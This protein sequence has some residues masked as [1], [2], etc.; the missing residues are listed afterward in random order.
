MFQPL[1]SLYTDAGAPPFASD[2]VEVYG[3]RFLT[4]ILI[5]GIALLLFSLLRYR[6]RTPSLAAW[7]LLFLGVVILPFVSTMFGTLLVFARGETVE[8]CGSCHG[9]MQPY[10][11]DMRDPNSQS[12]AALHFKNGYIPRSQCY[13]CHTSFGMFGTLEA[14]IGGIVQ[15]HRY[16]TGTFRRP[17]RMREPYRNDECLKCHAGSVKWSVSH[18]EEKDVILAGQV[19]CMDCHGQT[20][21]PH[22]V[23]RTP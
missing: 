7:S 3:A 15:V 10:V 21:P 13:T 9:A 14:K 19:R 8:F 6:G 16:Y 20:Y 12:L 5:F 2:P 22:L 1:V 11:D 23:G 18:A 17:A 4:A